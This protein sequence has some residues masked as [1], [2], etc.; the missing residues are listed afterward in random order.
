MILRTIAAFVFA[1]IALGAAHAQPAQA[2]DPAFQKF[3]ADLWK[4]AQAK[5]ITRKTFDN[6]FGY[7]ALLGLDVGLTKSGLI[8]TG[9]VRYSETDAEF[10][11]ISG[12]SAPYDPL[13]YELGLGWRF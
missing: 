11:Q 3:L 13:V 6:A 4:D 2:P 7:G 1:L 12:A 9:S 10:T 5:G 8:I